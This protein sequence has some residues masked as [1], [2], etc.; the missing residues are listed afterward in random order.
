MNSTRPYSDKQL[1]DRPQD[2]NTKAVTKQ[3]RS[4]EFRSHL[5]IQMVIILH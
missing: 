3:S 5:P 1:A 4:R 2:K